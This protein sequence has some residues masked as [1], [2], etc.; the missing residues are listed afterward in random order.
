[1]ISMICVGYGQVTFG[2]GRRQPA[3]KETAMDLDISPDLKMILDTVREFVREELFP[4]EKLFLSNEVDKLLPLLKEKREQAKDL[5]MW[6]PQIPREYGGMGL[7][8]R[9]FGHVSEALGQSLLGQY[10]FNCH[11]RRM[12]G[13][14]RY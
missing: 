13:I 5:G 4:L 9:E 7:S 11:R 14:W 8:L 1:M 6:L 10:V 2:N 3:N 12:L